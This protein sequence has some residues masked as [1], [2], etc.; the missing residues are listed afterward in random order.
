V[1]SE[2]I[3]EETM[4]LFAIK[5]ENSSDTLYD[6]LIKLYDI[7]K[8]TQALGINNDEQ[9][10]NEI[11]YLEFETMMLNTIEVMLIP[12]YQ[13]YQLLSEQKKTSSNIT[14]P[15]ASNDI[16][17]QYVDTMTKLKFKYADIINTNFKADF[18]AA[19]EKSLASG[20]NFNNCRKRLRVELPTFKQDGSLPIDYDSSIFVR[21]DESNPMIIR[22]LVTGPKD[23]PY[24]S[25]CMIFDF[26]TSE[27]YPTNCPSVKFMNHGNKRF[28]PNLYDCGKVCL[29]IL[30]QSYIGPPSSASERWNET[31]SLLQIMIS[32]QSQILIE[33]P[34]F[35][36]PGYERNIGTSSG[37]ASAK[38]YNENI[39]Q[40]VMDSAMLALLENPKSY[41][42]FED[43]II[44]HFRLKRDYISQ[45]IDKW[46]AEAMTSTAKAKF[47]K[48]GGRIKELL[49]QL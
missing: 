8:T 13:E 14:L 15:V 10:D 35:N 27:T 44:N 26:Y 30:G 24:D 37:D 9:D 36:E 42:Q 21:V 33:E 47:T 19:Y 25:S 11:Q 22:M 7:L 23:T 32:I 38:S 34:Y 12:L 49:A 43:V 39:R 3:H 2:L 41:P 1:I 16:R 48:T 46:T 17:K 40:Y 20:A 45:L 28:N 18:K 4:N 6:I 5:Y 29:S 31:S